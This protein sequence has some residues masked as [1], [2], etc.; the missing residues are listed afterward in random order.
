MSNPRSQGSRYVSSLANFTL[1]TKPYHSKLTEVAVEFRFDETMSVRV[2]DAVASRMAT[3]AGWLY[4]FTSGGPGSFRALPFQRLVRPDVLRPIGAPTTDLLGVP[5]VY[6][7]KSTLGYGEVWREGATRDAL[8][9]GHDYFHCYGASTLRVSLAPANDTDQ[10]RRWQPTNAEGVLATVTAVT[11]ATAL[12]TTNPTSPNRSIRSLLQQVEAQLSVTPNPAASAALT[13]LLTIIDTPDLPRSYEALLTALVDGGTPVIGGFTGWVG[14]DGTPPG[15]RYLDDALS[16]LTP[17]AYFSV[18]SDAR[19]R[20][21]GAASYPNG[22]VGPGFVVS[23]VEV[24]DV[25]RPEEWRIDV[26]GLGPTTLRVVGSTRGFIGTVVVGNRFTS[27]YL[28]FD[29]SVGA[30]V[31][32]EGDAVLLSPINRLTVGSSAPT[33]VWSLIQ[34]DPL[35]YSR[36]VFTSP[37]LGFIQD[38]DGTANRVTLLDPTLPTGTVT[39]TA[40]SPTTFALTS[41]V[42]PGY[43]GTVTV[44]ATFNDGRLGLRVNA[45]P[46]PYQVGDRYLIGIFNA[47]AV[48]TPPDVY[49]GYDLDSLDNQVSV[50]STDPAD[51]TFNRPFEFRYDSRYVD[52]DPASLGLV[53]EETAVNGRRFRLTARPDGAPLA[54][55]KKDGTT[56][57]NAIDL[58]DP[59]SGIPPDPGLTSVPV[60]S[61]PDDPNPAPDLL[62][63]QAATCRLEWSDDGFATSTFVADLPVG[64]TFTDPTL[65]ISFT[66][67][68]LARPLIGVTSDDGLGDPRVEGGDVITWQV[69]NEAPRLEP[70]VVTL[71]APAVATLLM[72]GDGFWAAPDAAWQVVF[73]SPTTY[74]V[75]ATHTSGPTFGAS[76]PGYP[77]TGALTTTG[78]GPYQGATYQD[79]LVHFTIVPGTAP[80]VAGAAFTFTTTARKPSILVHGSASGWMPEAV[81][82]EWYW[83]GHI[84][85][86]V[87]VPEALVFQGTGT[88]T[89]PLRPSDPD[90]DKVTVTRVRPD[91]PALTYTFTRLAASFI[92]ERDDAG[93]VGYA[94]LTGTFR[95]RYLTVDLTSPAA[96]FKVQVVPDPLPFWDGV[97]AV[98]VRPSI[99]ALGLRPGDTLAVRKAE[100]GQLALS[101]DYQQVPS[102]PALS[103]LYPLGIDD[104]F[105]DLDTGPS[106][107]PIETHSPEAII[108]DGWVPLTINGFDAL[109]SVASFPDAATALTVRTAAT[110]AVIGRITSLG[111][112]NE[113]IRFEWDEAFHTAYLPLGT[114]ASLVTYG[115]G[116]D[117][118]VRVRIHERV[119]FLIAGGVLLEDALFND[120]VNTSIAEAWDWLVTMQQVDAFTATIE[121]G[122]FGG[123]LPGYANLPYDAED[124][125]GLDLTS[126]AAAEGRYD[127]GA[128]LVDHYLRAQH[129]STLPS[130]TP[131]EVREQADLTSLLA[132]YLQPGGLASTSLSQVLAALDTDPFDTSTV[133]P[134]MGRP[135]LGLG[136]DI[137][138]RPTTTAVTA[139]AD[140]ASINLSTDTRGFDFGGF[141]VG[142]LDAIEP[143]TAILVASTVPP[144]PSPTPTFTTYE[145]LDTPLAT[146]VPAR[147]FILTFPTAVP[148]VPAVT[149]W[150]ASAPSPF[151]V[152][153]VERLTARSFTFNLAVEDQVKVVVT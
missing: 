62:V 70:T 19:L 16:Q 116:L 28:E 17:P 22:V 96:S 68:T 150:P 77:T 38:L 9:R 108:F 107:P 51:T 99:T 140:T 146:T 122:P 63:Y 50:Y 61:M 97:D 43:T 58:T 66:V 84:G 123:F 92:V 128:P 41:D 138:Q 110:D 55:L 131:D 65:G 145:A 14:E 86:K 11:Q 59:T 135:A 72:H 105:I 112:L 117:D 40:T 141:D 33:Q 48:A 126:L 52:F 132:D 118:K 35:A 74:E 91:A 57:S 5:H 76:L 90:G 104:D 25:E 121:D 29:T 71:V 39:L 21:S 79:D 149:V 85:F 109:G 37:G 100:A 125:L 13:D 64:S 56:V 73:T 78:T 94:P 153:V 2:E 127:T 124:A 53:V 120:D 8:V 82:G 26:V 34:T 24:V 47:P 1:D 23:G 60:F 49:F 113:P 42:E 81:I 4:G 139:V 106:S 151:T 129:L 3:K 87:S 69:V 46:T 103:A 142:G 144:V 152:P 36:P 119:N 80:F 88:S 18:F 31:P 114:R 89:A 101:L 75:R 111:T 93:V 10:S 7:K 115:T 95:D 143:A 147:A 30:G 6:A 148:T 102:P 20:E 83:N 137:D 98:V 133:A 12:D 32:A 136:I 67:P 54:T 15:S 45:G 130:P 27:T 44:G 134:E